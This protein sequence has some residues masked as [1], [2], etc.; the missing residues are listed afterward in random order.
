MWTAEYNN[1]YNTRMFIGDF[2]LYWTAKSNM[3]KDLMFF[4]GCGGGGGSQSQT[5]S[6]SIT[7]SAS[8]LVGQSVTLN[9]T[10]QNTPDFTLVNPP[11]GSGCV[12]SSV[13]AV[14]CTPTAAGTYTVTVT[15]T[16][17]T[18][19]NA[20]ATLTVTTPNVTEI[21]IP[22]TI[23]LSYPIAGARFEFTYTNGL[24]FESYEQSA[25]VQSA[26]PVTTEMDG[27]TYVGFFSR[28]NDF[29]PQNGALNIGNLVFSWSGASG[30]HVTM[31]EARLFVVRDTGTG[32]ART[33]EIINTDTR[34]V[35][36]SSSGNQGGFRISFP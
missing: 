33:D 25:A 23:S 2:G 34:T 10:R 15:A 19:K 35:S 24:E 31:T 16:A 8:A 26:I 1:I 11:S 30:Q 4:V 7:R 28:Y 17:D 20:S 22:V 36:L 6:I 29:T 27:N 21:E 18:T 5:V 3:M 13:N 12:K 14:I 9:V 32:P